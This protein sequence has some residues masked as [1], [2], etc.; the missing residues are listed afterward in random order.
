M[1]SFHLIHPDGRRSTHAI[2]AGLSL[3]RAAS[4]DGVA[5]IAAICGGTMTCATCHVYVADD[6]AARLPPPAPDEAAMLEMT[7]AERRPTSR[8]ACQIVL[9]PGLDGLSAELPATQC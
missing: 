4:D 7:A 5:G 3:M 6:W 1:A 2:R 8:L 9:H